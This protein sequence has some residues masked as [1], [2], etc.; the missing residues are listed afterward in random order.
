MPPVLAYDMVLST[1]RAWER[2]EILRGLGL[3][4]EWTTADRKEAEGAGWKG[5]AELRRKDIFIIR[6]LINRVEAATGDD[7]VKS[8]IPPT[9][10][11]EFLARL[12]EGSDARFGQI[13]NNALQLEYGKKRR[14]ARFDTYYFTDE[15]FTA[16]L[17]RYAK[18]AKGKGP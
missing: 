11:L 14:S 18:S 5:V 6:R 8:K 4:L 12:H 3:L 15:E 9:R 1:P 7:P 13:I 17:E 2:R 10:F 16:I